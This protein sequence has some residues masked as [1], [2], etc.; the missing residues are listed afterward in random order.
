MIT[1]FRKIEKEALKRHT[2]GFMHQS[3][4]N[5]LQS[6]T[7]FELEK[8]EFLKFLDSPLIKASLEHYD[9]VLAPDKTR[10]IKNGTICLI[11]LICRIAIDYGVD[12]ELSYSLS[13]Y[14]IYHLEQYEKEKDIIEYC[15]SIFLHYYDLIN[16]STKYVYEKNIASAIRYIE[17]NIYGKCS[18]NDVA[19]YVKLEPHYFSSLFKK[20]TGVSP[21]E[22]I[23]K[24]KLKEAK[25]LIVH[26]NEKIVDVALQLGFYDTSHFSKCF[27]KEYN[28]LPSKLAKI[29]PK[30]RNTVTKQN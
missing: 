2:Y 17:K 14:Y 23:L 21:S 19:N 3:Y 6:S 28:I 26:L 24:K 16:T 18:V 15:K 27:F 11:T 20:Q 5:E 1:D 25:R 12:L 30:R 13:D 8:E 9:G 10:S 29:D 22:Y 7:L 4:E